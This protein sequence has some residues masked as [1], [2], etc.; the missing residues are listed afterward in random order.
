MLDSVFPILISKRKHLKRLILMKDCFSF[1]CSEYFMCDVL[2]ET[3]Q[4]K[5]SL[6]KLMFLGCTSSEIEIDISIRLNKLWIKSCGIILPKW[7]L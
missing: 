3:K 7:I 4:S 2:I 5:T 1:E 6:K